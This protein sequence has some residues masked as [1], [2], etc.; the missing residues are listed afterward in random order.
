MNIYFT[1]VVRVD[2][3]CNYYI[4]G[5]VIAA[6]DEYNFEQHNYRYYNVKGQ[7]RNI[8]TWGASIYN[9]KGTSF[10]IYFNEFYSINEEGVTRISACRLI[11]RV[12]RTHALNI[13]RKIFIRIIILILSL[14]ICFGIIMDFFTNERSVIADEL[15]ASSVHKTFAN[16][17]DVDIQGSI[18]IIEKKE[19]SSSWTHNTYYYIFEDKE[20]T[21]YAVYVSTGMDVMDVSPIPKEL[22]N[23]LEIKKI[24]HLIKQ[25]KSKYWEANSHPFYSIE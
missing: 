1:G 2:C 15:L 5:S 16:M 14:Y 12:T 19:Y 10:W 3:H 18:T 25:R 11:L 6:P 22:L 24:Q 9:G 21:I 20:H 7:L 4:K 8:L 13:M 17:Y 23:E